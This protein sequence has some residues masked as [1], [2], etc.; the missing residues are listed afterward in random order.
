M[1]VMCCVIKP[2]GS[3]IYLISI[4]FGFVSCV[5]CLRN[6]IN[7]V[8]FIDLLNWRLFFFF[9]MRYMFCGVADGCGEGDTAAC[10]Y[11]IDDRR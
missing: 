3:R 7:I 9:E 5:N 4:G 2:S 11:S 6:E 10:D 1:F 8:I